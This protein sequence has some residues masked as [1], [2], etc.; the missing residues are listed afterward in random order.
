MMWLS[1]LDCKFVIPNDL[2]YFSLKLD[3]EDLDSGREDLE[4]NDL[5][6]P[7]PSAVSWK[8]PQVHEV[9]PV[10][11]EIV[12]HHFIFKKN[13][14]TAKCL[15]AKRPLRKAKGLFRDNYV[16]S[17]K[18]SEI[19][20]FFPL[21]YMMAKCHATMKD[22]CYTIYIRLVKGGGTIDWA[23]CDCE[24]GSSGVCCHIGAVLYAIAQIKATCTSNQCGWNVP[25]NPPL[26]LSPK[27]ICD[28][29]IEG[30]DN[31]K[32]YPGVHQA[33]HSTNPDGFLKDLLDGLKTVN[34]DCVLYKTLH[35]K[36]QINNIMF[37]FDPIF[38]VTDTLNTMDYQFTEIVREYFQK[39][40]ISVNES[41]EIEECTRGQSANAN[42]TTIRSFLLT[43]SNFGHIC[44]RRLETPPDNLVKALRGYVPIPPHVKSI[45]HGRKWESEARREYGRHHIKNCGNHLEITTTGLV[46]NPKWPYLGTSVDGIVKC[47][48]CGPLVLEIKCPY[49]RKGQLWRHMKVE[50]IAKNSAFCSAIEDGKVNLKKSHLYY[51]Q[52]MGQMAIHEIFWADFVIWTS[53]G[54]HVERIPFDQ[55]FWSN[56]TIKLEN[57]YKTGMIPEIISDRVRRGKKL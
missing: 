44:K 14:V 57:F 45:L 18:Y 26:P 33:S 7:P 23:K 42:W 5:E 10:T 11:D 19:N 48:R 16:F 40:T 50:E 43:S 37:K 28:I 2:L 41:K 22:K 1:G 17:L 25:K 51:Y 6:I 35:S 49:G 31:M 27:K 15:S 30:N 32:P 38:R 47:H 21:C 39:L 54:V 13:P 56:M 20:P 24:A 9:P 4:T 34:P 53:K 29:K 46:V 52:I 8:E 3:C 36:S 55:G 12:H